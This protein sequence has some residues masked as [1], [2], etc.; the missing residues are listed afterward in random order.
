MRV[1]F[2]ASL[3]VLAGALSAAVVRPRWAPDW[4]VAGA[5]AALLV[6]TGA[7]EAGAARAALG[8]IAPTVGF[9]AALLVLAEGCRREGLFDALGSL[10]ARAAG[11][12]PGAGR[13]AGVRAAATPVRLL[14]LVFAAAAMVTA[15]L[16]LDATVVL[17]TPV[18]LLTARRLR[19][20]P[21]P[22]LH[23]CAH[24]SNSASML[25]PISNLTNLLAFRA[26]GLSFG[27]FGAVML[28]PWL[29]ALAVEWLAFRGIF[30]DDLTQADDPSM[31]QR[32][33][34][35]S[36]QMSQRSQRGQTPC[37]QT[38]CARGRLPRYPLVVLA[39]SL[40]A[41]TACSSVGVP[42]AWVAA[43][44]AVAMTAPA[45][46]RRRVVCRELVRAAEPGLLVFI[47]A[48]AVVVRAAGDAGLGDAVGA[49]LP[50]G[51]GLGALLAITAVSAVLA[52]L[53]NNLPAT[54]LLLPLAA[55]AGPAAVLA[56]LVGVDVGPNLTYAGSLA[57]L[58][59][60]RV[61]RADGV[62][63]DLGRFTR[64]GLW[65]TPASLLLATVA[66]WLAAQLVL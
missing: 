66:L 62:E 23:A 43:A 53:V 6:L 64:L 4:L 27:R 15:V 51:T 13:G 50:G 33:Q 63:V 9:L 41:F 14:A 1:D 32:G 10:M 17:L 55:P 19:V 30:A 29:A 49:V 24:L 40:A 44:G 11:G 35:P 8:E 22:H 3:L 56:V 25:L 21:A 7:V 60:R 38:P 31:N 61:L 54:L 65:T 18:V 20:A 34:T 57:T 37:A 5:G 16:S 28:L 47:L 36:A 26:S 42:P 48:L 45:L 58:L 2:A 46:R 12:A 39:A 52:N 59:W